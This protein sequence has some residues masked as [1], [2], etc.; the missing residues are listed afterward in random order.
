MKPLRIGNPE[1][2]E[3]NQESEDETSLIHQE[4]LLDPSIT[5]QQL[6]AETETQILDFIRFEMG[7]T[8]EGQQNL[9]AVETAG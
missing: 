1:V 7:E 2:D 4:F 5:V 6:L 3:P 9:D 8:I